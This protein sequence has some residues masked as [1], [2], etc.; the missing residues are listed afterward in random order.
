MLRLLSHMLRKAVAGYSFVPS[1]EL[2]P[3]SVCSQELE[4]NF[5]IHGLFA[6]SNQSRVVG[7]SLKALLRCLLAGSSIGAG[8]IRTIATLSSH[9][10][11]SELAVCKDFSYLYVFN[12]IKF[13]SD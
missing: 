3:F 11:F 7:D 6:S 8:C 9:L 5:K 13:D 10:T 12:S 4:F 1:T 2:E